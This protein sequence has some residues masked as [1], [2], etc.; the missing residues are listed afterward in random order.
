M[1]YV[2]KN[3]AFQALQWQ[4]HIGSQEQLTQWIESPYQIRFNLDNAYLLTPMGE[5]LVQPWDYIVK[6]NKGYYYPVPYEDF[7]E[8]FVCLP[9][10]ENGS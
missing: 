2:K 6:D 3:E 9:Q 1:R 10:E 8:N 5:L 4:V 7:K